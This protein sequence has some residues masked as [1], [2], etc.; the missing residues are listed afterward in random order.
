MLITAD[1]FEEMYGEI[2]N[3][4]QGKGKRSVQIFIAPTVDAI[5]CYKILTMLFQCDG[6]LHTAIPVNNQDTLVRCFKDALKHTDVHSVIFIDCGANLDIEEIVPETLEIS[7]YVLD[8]HRPFYP[9]NVSSQHIH[10][11]THLEYLQIEDQPQNEKADLIEGSDDCMGLLEPEK[12]TPIDYIRKTTVTT[13]EFFSESVARVALGIAM[14]IK[15]VSKVMYWY[16]AIGLADQYVTL[17]INA[18][19][20]SNAMDFFRKSLKLEILESTDLLQ[21]VKTDMCIKMDCQLMLL[22]HWTLYDSLFHTR[23]IASRLGIWN[24]RGKEKF[25]VLIADMG[26]PL[27]QAKQNYRTM[28]LEMKNKFL[29]KIDG[30]AKYYKFEN[31]FLP[32][33]FRKHGS[34]YTISAIDATYAIST[35]IT[36]DEEDKTWQTQF[37]E[38]YKLVSSDIAEAYKPG[39]EKCIEV[40]KVMV[41]TGI[42]LMLSKNITNEENRYRFCSVTDPLLAS[43]FKATYKALQ[44]AQFLAETASRR[45]KKWLPLVLTVLDVEKKTFVVVGYSSPISIK[46]MNYFGAKFM[47]TAEKLKIVLLQKSFD[48]YIAEIHRDNLIRYKRALVKCFE[49]I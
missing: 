18:K 41:E 48:S 47:Q 7:V 35:V 42:M 3:I 28:G 49:T 19:T 2:C 17:K 43:K 36:N 23:E 31:M 29:S 22:R 45:Y 21:T 16:A 37:W 40:N 1:K 46:N 6:I 10:L 38:G 11:L 26:I 24:S 9:K 34:D 15:R 14:K 39:F 32:A 12:E 25:D 30:Y 5:V 4:S 33:F 13:G 8:S 44:L 27:A 20:Y